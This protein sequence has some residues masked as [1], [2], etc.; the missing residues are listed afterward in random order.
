MSIARTQH[1][2]LG[3]AALALTCLATTTGCAEAP[4][5]PT[6]AFAQPIDFT[7]ACPGVSSTEGP[8]Y[9]G[10]GPSEVFCDNSVANNSN[11]RLLGLILNQ[12]PGGVLLVS[13]HAT[14]SANA[15]GGVIDSD[16]FIP[17]FTS[18]RVPDKP[19]RILRAADW[20]SFYVISAGEPSV[21]KIVVR[22]F[23]AAPDTGQGL[24]IG[25]CDNASVGAPCYAITTFD[26]PGTPSNATIIGTSLVVSAAWS[27]EVWRYDLA[28]ENPTPT[29]TALPGK[30]DQVQVLKA[31]GAAER[32]IVTWAE[33]GVI[34]LLSGDL[35]ILDEQP[36]VAACADGLDNDADG[37]SDHLDPDCEGVDDEDEGTGPAIPAVA[38]VEPA[39]SFAGTTFC[40]DGVDNDGNGLT[41]AEEGTGPGERCES[42]DGEGLAECEDGIDNDGDGAIDTADTSCYSGAGSLESAVGPF[43]FYQLAVVEAGAAGTFAYV[44]DAQ[45][46]RL[47]TYS[48]EG[49]VLV[50]QNANAHASQA[51]KVA[52]KQSEDNTDKTLP[53]VVT[54]AFPGLE[55]AEVRD[56]GL[57]RTPA[58]LTPMR[59]RGRLWAHDLTGPLSNIVANSTTKFTPGGCKGSLAECARPD[60]DGETYWVFMPGLN[61]ELNMLE[62]VVRGVPRHR[63]VQGIENPSERGW[64]LSGSVALSLRGKRVSSSEHLPGYAVMGPTSATE[65]IVSEVDN[66]SPVRQRIAGIYPPQLSPAELEAISE[67]TSGDVALEP[68]ERVPTQTWT[69]TYEGLV[70]QTTGAL[71]RLVTAT[72]FYAP[73]QRFCERGAEVGDWLVLTVPTA[74]SNP[75]IHY[76]QVITVAGGTCALEP[77]PTMQIEAQ[78]STVG[79]DTLTVDPATARLVPQ[80]RELDEAA[81]RAGATNILNAC[82]K[83][84]ETHRLEQLMGNGED[85]IGFIDASAQWA[86][87]NFPTR[88]SYGIRAGGAWTVVG[89]KTGFAHRQMWDGTACVEDPALDIR[90]T[91]R[92]KTE[93]FTSAEGLLPYASCPPTDSELEAGDMERLDRPF[94]FS[95]FSFSV[96]ML[97]GCF[98]E[99][100]TRTVANDRRDTRWQFI[101]V[102]PDGAADSL[103]GKSTLTRRVGAM[104]TAR[105]IVY[106]DTAANRLRLLRFW[107]GNTAGSAFSRLF[108]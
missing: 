79:M 88:L 104:E 4:S 75:L 50:R 65:T 60:Q 62:S 70:P 14:S 82:E 49:D 32:L 66:V 53:A 84:L 5:I 15:G 98:G 29:A 58:S 46:S 33:R 42:P 37:L 92:L 99:G 105:A 93:T 59:V 43:G 68:F 94:S 83:A 40:N 18:I 52:Y 21:S 108:D 87:D 17:G 6:S 51:P 55:R 44:A 39:S 10:T 57:G 12:D 100:A 80:D 107:H 78:I 95:N 35:Q 25:N 74:S 61:G 97:P 90:H 77:L 36:I 69:V 38:A 102:G 56:I 41:D 7:Y 101:V 72:E 86:V 47:L 26:L 1:T 64:G 54:T 2:G 16:P 19:I 20:R 103:L 28:V 24:V 89:G 11:G 63:F 3:L 13:V 22:G 30:I 31:D 8:S 45:R 91:G 48:L 85:A 67:D 9:D 23:S 34:S 106:M 96:Y 27:N 71:G 73:T 76:D 81:I